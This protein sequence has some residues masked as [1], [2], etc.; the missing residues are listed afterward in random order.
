[1]GFD[2]IA[3][4]G[5]HLPDTSLAEPVIVS[6]YSTEWV[7]R[8]LTNGYAAIDPVVQTGLN[9]VIPFSWGTRAQNSTLG[10]ESQRLM[11]EA[12]VFGIKHGFTVPIHGA[13]GELAALSIAIPD[14]EG[15]A[16]ARIDAYCHRIHLMALHFHAHMGDRILSEGAPRRVRLS[17]R[18]VECLLWTSQG[19]TNWEIAGILAIS[20]NTVREYIKSACRKLG[21]F[22]KNHAVVKAI[23]LGLVR[24]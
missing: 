17:P 4:L 24:P 12:T 15:E 22:N 16:L 10:K 21:V 18:E 19:K 7:N 13:R 9:S 8:Y 20:E 5:L 1:M 14:K 11:N 2:R 3:Y 6:T 23:M